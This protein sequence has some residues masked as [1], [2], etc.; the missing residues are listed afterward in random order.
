MGDIIPNSI[1]CLTRTIQTCETEKKRNFVKLLG[2]CEK[3]YYENKIKA[4]GEGL[5]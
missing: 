5:K 4:E 3:S 1:F 2:V